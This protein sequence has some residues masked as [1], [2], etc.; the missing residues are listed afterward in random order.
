MLGA[1]ADAG[2]APDLADTA[3]VVGP[4]GFAHG[5]TKQKDLEIGGR[6]RGR[7]QIANARPN[8]FQEIVFRFHRKA[9]CLVK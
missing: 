6:R 7:H 5:K 4:L 8:C 2:F 3:A 9:P 1:V